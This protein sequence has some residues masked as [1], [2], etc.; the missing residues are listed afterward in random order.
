MLVLKKKLSTQFPQLLGLIRAKE[1]IVR[2][3]PRKFQIKQ[4][5]FRIL[6]HFV[7]STN[8]ENFNLHNEF[9]FSVSSDNPPS[10]I[11]TQFRQILVLLFQNKILIRSCMIDTPPVFQVHVLIM[12]EP[13]CIHSLVTPLFLAGRGLFISALLNPISI[14]FPKQKLN[15]RLKNKC[16]FLAL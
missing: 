2:D 9:Y 7:P 8:W 5:I 11:Y 1:N 4:G 14:Q 15:F 13:K 3:F 6:F 10:S 12:H 16:I